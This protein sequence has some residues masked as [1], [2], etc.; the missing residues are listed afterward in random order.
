MMKSILFYLC[1][2]VALQVGF[3]QNTATVS[4]TISNPKGDMVYLKYYTDY[5]SYNEVIVDST[6]LDKKGNFYMTFKWD[7]PS[8]LT[9]YHGD[10]VTEM[11]MSPG[12]NLK[13][14]LDTK[15]FDETVKYEGKGAYLN[16]YLAQKV[17]L[18]PG[19]GGTEYKMNEKEFTRLIDSI[20][21]KEL[22]YFKDYFAK[23][24]SREPSVSSFIEN[25]EMNINYTWAVNKTSYPSYHKYLNQIKG[26]FEVSPAY[27]DFLKEI[28]TMNTKAIHS[29]M[30]LEF[31]SGYVEQEISK[32]QQKDTSASAM[33]IKDQYI[34]KNL[35]GEIKEYILAEWAF[36]TLTDENDIATGKEILDKLIMQNPESQ[37]V[38]LIK[39]TMAIAEMLQP[40]NPAPDFTYSDLEGKMVSLHDFRGKVVYLDIWASWCGPC[41]GEIPFA[42]KLE[43][44]M[45]GKDVVFLSVS[46]DVD[47]DAWKKIIKDKSMGGIHLISKGNFDSQ[48]AKLYNVKGIPMYLIIGKDGNIVSNNAARPSGNVKAELEKLLN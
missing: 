4:G 12:D 18:F 17:L 39:N 41:R 22:A 27:Y 34:E 1:M 23:Q 48:I 32:L 37:Y 13:L 8:P 28:P 5:I 42:K 30:Y 25:E 19:L 20:H 36:N 6:E 16:N 14:T 44:E 21:M 43:E 11:Y 33:E 10:E 9:F 29:M 31:L 2:F 24:D 15:E 7:H 45:K 40:G 46:V 3:S 26:S 35:S 47:E 38:A